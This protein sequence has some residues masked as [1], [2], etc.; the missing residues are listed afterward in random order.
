MVLILGSSQCFAISRVLGVEVTRSS[1]FSVGD[2]VA[3]DDGE[4]DEQEPAADA[5]AVDPG[6]VVGVAATK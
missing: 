1:P 3:D 2:A 4:E 6:V 5:A